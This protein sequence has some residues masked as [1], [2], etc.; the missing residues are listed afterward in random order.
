[1]TGALSPATITNPRCES[2][3]TMLLPDWA[4]LNAAIEWLAHGMW[5]IAWWRCKNTVTLIMVTWVIA[6]DNRTTCHQVK[7]PVPWA[8]HSTAAFSTAQSGIN[9]VKSLSKGGVTA[10]AA[11]DGPAAKHQ[12]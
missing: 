7:S 9:I 2:G 6:K 4:V 10:S 3:L 1:M 11:N 12:F 5:D 8:S